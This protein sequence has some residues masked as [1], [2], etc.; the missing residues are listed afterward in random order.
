[1]DI[2]A[3]GAKYHLVVQDAAA[4]HSQVEQLLDYAHIPITSLH[5]ISPSLEDVF[6]ALTNEVA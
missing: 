1:M 6:V 4:A 5:Q 2:N 3:F